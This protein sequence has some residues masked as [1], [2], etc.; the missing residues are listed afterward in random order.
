DRRLE[1]VGRRARRVDVVVDDGRCGPGG[2]AVGRLREL[3]VGLNPVPVLVGEIDVAGEGGAGGEVLD[4]AAAEA[5]VRVNLTGR[6]RDGRGR[7]DRADRLRGG[8]GRGAE[9]RG[10][11]AVRRE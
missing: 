2:A 4:D 9:S 6:A 3:H 5:R 8:G 1:L 10:R 11:A 7:G